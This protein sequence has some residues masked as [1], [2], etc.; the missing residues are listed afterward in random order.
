[1]TEGF[2]LGRTLPNG[3]KAEIWLASHTPENAFVRENDV[4]IVEL[5]FSAQRIISK[6]KTIRRRFYKVFPSLDF[7]TLKATKE[8]DFEFSCPLM[9]GELWNVVIAHCHTLSSTDY[10]LSSFTEALDSE[11]KNT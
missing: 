2:I 6:E 3:I 7:N 9:D 8:M 10:I 5:R 1:M 11:Q 4:A